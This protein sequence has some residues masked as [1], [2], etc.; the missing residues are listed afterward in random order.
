MSCHAV[1]DEQD[2]FHDV[3]VLSLWP[4]HHAIQTCLVRAL[5]ESA[6]LQTAVTCVNCCSIV[7]VSSISSRYSS[8]LT[9]LIAFA[10]TNQLAVHQLF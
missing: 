10:F 4:M 6:I 9:V 2:L 5:G 3:N 8:L 1:S 7:E